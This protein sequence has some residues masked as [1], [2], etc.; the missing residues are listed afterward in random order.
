MPPRPGDYPAPPSS[1]RA[2]RRPVPAISQAS[3]DPRPQRS[4]LEKGGQRKTI[5]ENLN[6]QGDLRAGAG[7]PA[8]EVARC[9]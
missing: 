8:G 7:P 5:L 4:T 2:A 1:E 3:G 9:A 6:S